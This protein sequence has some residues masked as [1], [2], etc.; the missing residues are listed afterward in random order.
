MIRTDPSVSAP[1]NL[2]GSIYISITAS[3]SKVLWIKICQIHKTIQIQYK[4]HSTKKKEEAPLISL[5]S[6][7]FAGKISVF[8]LAPEAFKI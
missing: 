1:Y 6:V 2:T 5:R 3:I 4:N 7:D 8:I